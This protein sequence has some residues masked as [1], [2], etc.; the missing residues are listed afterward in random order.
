[1][2]LVWSGIVRGDPDTSVVFCDIYMY[3]CNPPWDADIIR[4]IAP[5]LALGN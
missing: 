4:V 2:L 5:A 3:L 1:M